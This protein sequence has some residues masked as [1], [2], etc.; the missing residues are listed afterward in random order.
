MAGSRAHGSARRPR[1][2][3]RVACPAHRRRPACGGSRGTFAMG[4]VAFY[5]E[6]RPV[7]RVSV[8]GFWMDETPV[9]AA[10]FRRFVRDTVRDR[11]RAPT[12]PGGLPG[13]RPRPARP[14]LARLPRHGGPVDPTTTGTG[15]R[16]FPARSGSATGGRGRRST[17]ATVTRSFTLPARTRRRTRRGPARSRRPSRSGSS[18]RAVGSTER[19]SPGATTIF[20]TARR[21]RTPGRASFP[22]RT[23]R[24][25]GF[26]GTSPV[27]SFPP[28]GYGLYDITG[29]V[30]EWTS[31]WY[32]PRHPDEVASQAASRATRA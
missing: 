15:G 11:R 18:P 31:D 17:A 25:D 20:R 4:S 29:N 23:S 10:D 27:G 22:G 28:N 1:Q 14:R 21:W 26:R 19:P 12:R 9:T 8:D 16:T 24:L 5:P 30:W 2:T 3:D 6:E 7:H 32:V 13:R